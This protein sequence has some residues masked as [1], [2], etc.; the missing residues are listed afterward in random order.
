MTALRDLVSRPAHQAP[1]LDALRTA[2]VLL[3]IGGHY[4]VDL[5]RPVTGLDLTIASW[6]VFRWSWTGVDL[7]FVLSGYLIGRQ[8]WRE[9][10]QTGSIQI[11]RFIL[12][13]G[14]RIWPLYFTFMA[15]LV[16]SGVSVLRWADW[17]FASNYAHG[18]YHRGWSLS[19]EEQ[20][21]IVVPLL[22]AIVGRRLKLKQ[23]GWVL[24]LAAAAVVLARA[25]ALHAYAGTL[26]EGE[27][28]PVRI[29]DAF[30][31]HCDALLAGLSL[32]LASVLWP[33]R[34]LPHQRNQISW[35]ALAGMT[36]GCTL[37]LLLWRF[38]H[39]LYAFTA[40]A[41]IFVSITAFVLVD[42]SW[43]TRPLH[44]RAF[45]PISRLSYGMYL[46]HLLV[47]PW[48]LAASLTLLQRALHRPILTFA[49]GGIIAVAVS[50]AVA[51]VFFVCV[52]YPGLWLRGRF[53]GHTSPTRGT[54][55]GNGGRQPTVVTQS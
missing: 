41:L 27:R 43:L 6:P 44:A 29:F 35:K 5:F 48:F 15:Y 33:R 14:F 45:Y 3:V 51:V 20:F 47:L 18:G 25:H 49:L 31:L 22:I 17:L 42:R 38:D 32:A 10:E 21:Y 2:A 40:L 12:R 1:A 30:H 11:G 37:G 19:T 16:I 36:S 26:Q 8:L 34:F 55:A 4:S 39:R 23:F 28:L 54:S 46:N 13:R 53:L 9:F 50:I 52:E 7:F 24:G